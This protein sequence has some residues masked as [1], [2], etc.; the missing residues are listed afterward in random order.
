MRRVLLALVTLLGLSACGTDSAPEQGRIT[1][2]AFYREKILLPPGAELLVTLEDVSRADAPSSLITEHR[3]SLDSP[4]PYAFELTYPTESIEPRAR[5]ALRAK[6][7]VG[8][9]LRFITDT[10]VD[11]FAE[12][13]EGVEPQPVRLLMVG[14]NR[15]APELAPTPRNALGGLWQV[16]RLNG[17]VLEESERVVT[18]RFDGSP[19]RVSGFSGCNQYSGGATEKDDSLAFGQLMSTMMA[20]D[21]SRMLLE[22]R[23]LGLLDQVARF[24]ISDDT[25][26][27][28]DADG[29]VLI[30]A[31]PQ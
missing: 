16:T 2:E 27:L 7:F 1:G 24:S 25:L 12:S 21:E 18:L 13:S 11:P 17:E 30:L 20:C 15:S 8:D 9:A 10:H 5:Y 19:L 6:I 29:A 28:L 22:K 14:V 26:S 4:P 3:Q 31:S 23:F